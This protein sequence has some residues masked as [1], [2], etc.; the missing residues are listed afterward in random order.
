MDFFSTSKQYEGVRFSQDLG[1]FKY[2]FLV[3]NILSEQQMIA[4]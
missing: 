2:D 1:F 3:L 4:I